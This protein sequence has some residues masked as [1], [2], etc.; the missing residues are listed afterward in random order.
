M[1]FAIPVLGWICG[2]LFYMLVAVPAYL[3]WNY[4]APTYFNFLPTA[5]H[6]IPYWDMTMLLCAFSIFRRFFS[7]FGGF[8]GVFSGVC[9]KLSK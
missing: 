6:T 4:V 5:W 9:E 3:V 2:L 7:P 1:F 8:G